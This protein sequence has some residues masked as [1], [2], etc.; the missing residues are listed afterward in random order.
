M[1]KNNS[2]KRSS[3]RQPS[4]RSESGFRRNTVVISKKQ[5]EIAEHKQSVTQRQIDAKRR[6]KSKSVQR[7][8]LLIFVT[9]LFVIFV[10]RMRIQ[11]VSV[12]SSKN[13][14]VSAQQLALYEKTIRSF[15][16]SNAPLQQS[17]LTDSAALS[18]TLRQAHPEVK[19]VRTTTRN[20]FSTEMKTSVTFRQP[21]FVWRGLGEQQ[22]I[23]EEG[24]LFTDN[25]YKDIAVSKLPLIEDQGGAAVEAGQTVLTDTIVSDI[26]A[27]Y[28]QLPDLYSGGAKVSKILLPRSTR[29]IQAQVT[30]QNYVIKFS[31][32]RSIDEQIGELRLLLDLLKQTNT[33]PSSYIDVRVPNKVYYK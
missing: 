25:M 6:M 15:I 7:R 27:L 26:A 18:K 9:V 21:V 28:K 14:P 12:A 19:T 23:D 22:F 33:V 1:F 32:E 4:A 5:R 24:V 29:E 2:K 3:L 11:T 17:W 30:G 8:V 13:A 16:D 20:P 10:Y 31:A